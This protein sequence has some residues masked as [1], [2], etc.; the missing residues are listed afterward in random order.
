MKT[1]NHYKKNGF[2]FTLHKRIGDWAIFEGYKTGSAVNIELI[3][4]QSHNGREIA[5]TWC[6]PAEYPP[7]NEQWGTKG[8]T[9]VTLADA[10]SRLLELSSPIESDIL[11]TL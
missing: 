6:E 7:S 5:G 1:L 4:V 3:Q 2:E 11:S 9:F 10:E 8:F